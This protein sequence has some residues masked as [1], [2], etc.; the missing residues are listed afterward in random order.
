MEQLKKTT[1]SKEKFK[2]FVLLIPTVNMTEKEIL[3]GYT[4]R[5]EENIKF[6]CCRLGDAIFRSHN[7][8]AVNIKTGGEINESVVTRGRTHRAEI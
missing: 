2:N 1:F 3:N 6:T 4:E 7:N 8:S 5:T